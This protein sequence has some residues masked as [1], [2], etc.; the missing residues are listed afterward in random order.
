MFK[1]LNDHSVILSFHKYLSMDHCVPDTVQS[2]RGRNIRLGQ[3]KNQ[4]QSLYLSSSELSEE[5][6]VVRFSSVL[7]VRREL[8]PELVEEQEAWILKEYGI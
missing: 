3:I 8:N 1:I 2:T 4:A 7:C 6:S 5:D